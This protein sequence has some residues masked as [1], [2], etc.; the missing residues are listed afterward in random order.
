LAGDKAFDWT[1][2]Q[3]GVY[4]RALPE[5][6]F[7]HWTTAR[8]L[9]RWFLRSAAF[10]PS[11]GRP[12]GKREAALVPAFDTLVPRADD[13]ICCAGDRYRWEWYYNDGA[14]GE[15]WIIDIRPPT[16]LVFGFGEKMTVEV[17]IRKQ[18]TWCEV[19]LRQYDIPSSP[20]ARWQMHMG[21]RTGW[22]FFLTNLKS[23]MEKG[24]DLREVERA[25]TKQM[26]LVNI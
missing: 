11:A 26:H 4:I 14:V 7:R 3:L 8:G 1:Q 17:T 12:A 24:L 23:V 20:S 16:R 22:V 13:E 15:D 5:D 9:C 2:F 18:G 19:N 25:R 10:A 6:V 21:C